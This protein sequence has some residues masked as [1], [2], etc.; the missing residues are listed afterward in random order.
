MANSALYNYVNLLYDLLALVASVQFSNDSKTPASKIMSPEM[1][2]YKSNGYWYSIP[3]NW[4]T[5]LIDSAME[6]IPLRKRFLLYEDF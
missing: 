4:L 3:R 2:F 1:V 6:M 5:E